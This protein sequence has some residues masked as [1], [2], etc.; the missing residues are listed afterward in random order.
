MFKFGLVWLGLVRFIL[1]WNGFKSN[2]IAGDI[3]RV[4]DKAVVWKSCI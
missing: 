1:V 3:Y 4:K 2:S